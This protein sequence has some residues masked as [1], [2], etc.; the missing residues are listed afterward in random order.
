MTRGERR[1]FVQEEQLGPAPGREHH[2]MP[3]LE[4]EPAHDPALEPPRLDDAPV[5][6]VQHAA[7][8]DPGAARRDRVQRAV[9]IDPVLERH[10]AQ[11]GVPSLWRY[12]PLPP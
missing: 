2:A 6:V 1:R 11:Y 7:V 3:P 10:G 9:R 12:R 4:L 8:A 5:L